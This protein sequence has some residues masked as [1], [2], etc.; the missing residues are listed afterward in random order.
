MKYLFSICFSLLFGINIA[1]AGSLEDGIAAFESKNYENA[2]TLLQ[3]EA[4]KGVAKA[5][6]L[7]ARM[8]VNGWGVAQDRE[9]PESVTS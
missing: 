9:V 6:G 2:L 4:D 5:Q 3:P 1:F 8:Y 7:V